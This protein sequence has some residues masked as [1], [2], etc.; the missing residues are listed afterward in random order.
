MRR[1]IASGILFLLCLVLAGPGNATTLNE[2]KV[3]VR[4]FDFMSNPPR[5]RTAL[6]IIYDGQ[7]KS[8]VDDARAIQG[9]LN[10]GV[11]SVKAELIPT[12]VDAHQLEDT[13]S[14][15]I[16]IV[17][18]GTEAYDTLI[19][20]FARKNHALTISSDLSCVHAATCA[21]GIASSPRVEVIVNRAVASSC[22]VEFSEAFRMMVREY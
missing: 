8:S 17:A 2:L 3:G 14:Y 15:R 16:A 12:L 21:V 1:V 5:G 9:W 22:S 4:V 10:S 18:S 19:F 20:N 11:S 13:A 6:A 7:N